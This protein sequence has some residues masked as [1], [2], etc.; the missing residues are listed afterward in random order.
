MTL[1]ISNVLLIINVF[2]FCFF[3]LRMKKQ[4]STEKY[5]RLMQE[6]MHS[7][8]LDFNLQ[9]DRR[10]MEKGDFPEAITILEE[11]MQGL[12][13]LISDAD[14]RFNALSHKIEA[15]NK[16]SSIEKNMESVKNSE[17]P[18]QVHD[19]VRNADVEESKITVYSGR[20]EIAKKDEFTRM[21]I[22]EMSK[23][24][25][26]NDYIAQKLSIPLAE[27]ELIYGEQRIVH[28]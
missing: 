16:V 6:R 25:W 18:L 7:I 26:A 3:F 21:K 23:S 15:V 14:G 9:P 17:K 22:F 5:E 2:L 11:R 13:N 27:V 12:K 1:I 24:G 4:F 28:F 10:C 19:M 8:L 20:E